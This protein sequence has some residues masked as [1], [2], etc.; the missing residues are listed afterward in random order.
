MAVRSSVPALMTSVCQPGDHDQVPDRVGACPDEVLE[1]VKVANDSDR[2]LP[3]SEPV[4]T[5]VDE[6][7]QAHNEITKLEVCGH[8]AAWSHF[9]HT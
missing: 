6:V 1:P 4:L 5:S 7:L 9:F 3:E 2:S 8:S